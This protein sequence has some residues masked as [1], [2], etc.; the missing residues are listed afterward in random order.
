MRWNG[1]GSVL[2]PERDSHC[3]LGAG[4]EVDCGSCHGNAGIEADLWIW[5]AFGGCA[6]IALIRWEREG[7]QIPSFRLHP[8]NQSELDTASIPTSQAS[9]L[10]HHT[11][12]LP[13]PLSTQ[14]R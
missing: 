7:Y 5:W 10:P 3:S 8:D 12:P 11:L 6:P 9:Q 14:D 1:V 4:V 13:G 2:R